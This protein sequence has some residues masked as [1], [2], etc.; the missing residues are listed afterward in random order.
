MKSKAIRQD[1]YLYH[2][3]ARCVDIP[4]KQATP[5]GSGLSVVGLNSRNP[6]E[7]QSSGKLHLPGGVGLRL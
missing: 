7:G 3:A 4:Q 5:N 1:G 6:L 2:G